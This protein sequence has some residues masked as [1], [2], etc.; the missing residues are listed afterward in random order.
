SH[1]C[2]RRRPLDVLLVQTTLI[3][4]FEHPMH[5]FDAI[6]ITGWSSR[7]PRNDA[8]VFINIGVGGRILSDFIAG[9]Y[10]DDFL[11]IR[12]YWLRYGWL[13]T[14]LFPVSKRRYCKSGNGGVRWW[15]PVEGMGMAD[16]Q[17]DRSNRICQFVH[18]LPLCSISAHTPPAFSCDFNLGCHGAHSLVVPVARAGL[19]HRAARPPARS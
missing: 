6:E 14:T 2:A 5:F 4:Q 9:D 1:E 13:R 10:L 3:K 7:Q 15:V 8:E 12:F 17:H 19:R 18:G 11:S 16:R